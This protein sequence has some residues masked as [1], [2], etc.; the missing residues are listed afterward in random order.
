MAT[1]EQYAASIVEKYAVVAETDSPAHRAADAVIP[2][3]KQ[4]GKQYLQGI[5]LSGAYAKGTAVSL[6]SHVDLL[7]SLS[8]VPGLGMKS[9]FWSLFEFL[10]DRDL[11]PRTRNVSMQVE[12]EGL[13]VDLIPACRDRATSRNLLFN[14][15]TGAAVDTDVGRHVHVVTNS[16]RQHEICALKIW[17]ERQ[18]V[19]FPSLYL[20]LTVLRALEHERFG[21]VADNVLTVLRYIGGR[22]EQTIVRDPANEENIVSSDLKAAEKQVIAKAAR[23]ALYDENWKKILW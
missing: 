8:L 16:G 21:Q 11:R 5:M 20:E 4:W 23:D 6:S 9:V 15:K 10:T 18:K 17:R 2:L 13:T 1:V 3:V 14:K 22:L 19:D 12:S 7:I